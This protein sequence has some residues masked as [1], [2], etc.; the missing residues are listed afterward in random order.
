MEGGF[1]VL[2][3]AGQEEFDVRDES[4]EGV[5]E[6]RVVQQDARRADDVVGGSPFFLNRD[7]GLRWCGSGGSSGARLGMS[8]GRSVG[9]GTSEPCCCCLPEQFRMSLGRTIFD[10]V[11]FRVVVVA[12]DAGLFEALRMMLR[13]AQCRG[14]LSRATFRRS[15]KCPF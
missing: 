15:Q 11:L 12:A 7:G 3:V 8:D 13:T 9:A 4:R 6:R 2:P 10:A 5:G 1:V 14:H